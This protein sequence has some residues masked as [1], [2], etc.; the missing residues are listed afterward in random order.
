MSNLTV[1]QTYAQK[2]PESLPSSILFKH[3]SKNITIF[4]GY[5]KSIFHFLILPRIQKPDPVLYNLGT[6]LNSGDKVRAKEVITSLWEDAQVVKKEI[7][8]EMVSR[9]G[10]KWDIWIGFHGAPSM[11]H[12]HLHVLSSD[13]LSEKMKNKKHYNSFHPKL[14][15]FLDIQEILE[16]FDAEP[17]FFSDMVKTLKPTKYEPILKE[18]LA[19]FRCNAEM[20]NM[21]LLKKH[22]EEEWDKLER[23]GREIAARK[24]KAE[25][26]NTEPRSSANTS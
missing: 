19:C 13:L 2:A 15:F 7:S 20:K 14:G 26:S 17:T 24:R 16:W 11:G 23:R 25:A 8:D 1:L 9:Y 5:P 10:F 3:S 22:L 6:L 21:P 12:L 18:P 4:D